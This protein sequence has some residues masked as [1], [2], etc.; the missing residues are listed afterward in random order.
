MLN[1]MMMSPDGLADLGL[2]KTDVLYGEDPG[3]C[4]HTSLVVD[5]AVGSASLE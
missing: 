3:Y 1:T 4:D 2:R 5:F